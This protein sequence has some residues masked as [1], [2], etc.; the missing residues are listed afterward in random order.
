MNMT[1][2]LIFLNVLLI[3]ALIG[4]QYFFV[5]E[6][7]T[8]PPSEEWSRSFT[9]HG[10]EGDYKKVISIPTETGY[11]I[12]LLNFKKLD[13][14]DCSKDLEC[15][16]KW[17][18]SKLNPYK[19]TWSDGITTYFIQDNSLIRSISNQ[20]ESIISSNVENFQKSGETLVYWLTN[21]EVVIQKGEQPPVSFTPEYPVYTSNIVD[22]RIFILTFNMQKNRY[23]V[24]DVTNDYKELFQFDLSS[25]ENLSSMQIGSGDNDQFSLIIDTETFSGGKRTKVI[26]RATFNL[27]DNQNPTLTKLD[28]ADKESGAKLLDIRY[29]VLFTDEGGTKITFSAY[30]YDQEGDKTIKIFVGSLDSSLVQASPIT[31]KGD[32]FVQPFLINAETIAYFKLKGKERSLM[33]S[34]ATD[35]KRLQSE[36][37]L[38]GDYKQTL[39]NLFTLLVNGVLLI[40]LSFTWLLPAL[41]IVFLTLIGLQTLRKP[42]A[43]QVAF[44]MNTIVLILSQLF[45]FST[46]LHPERMIS[47]A[48]Y[49][50]EVWH[51]YLVIVIAGI[52]SLLPVF[53]TRTKVTEDSFN[54]LLLYTTLMNL[55][56]LFFIIGPYII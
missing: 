4:F 34:S 3:T 31:K 33:Y 52:G 56:F 30:M 15:T 35:E 17:T 39:F 6:S 22:E 26:R 1:K 54:Q 23:A 50:S 37:V 20:E 9:F 36:Q 21:Q 14:I 32:L 29:P 7:Q 8:E 16:K 5:L 38:E 11:G 46:I 47:S 43:F 12:S 25:R 10:T 51:V 19:N 2:T 40:L 41:G 44:Y 28:F 53:L 49:L 27:T 42:Y 18:N 55:L 45:I 48:P 24:I 13:F